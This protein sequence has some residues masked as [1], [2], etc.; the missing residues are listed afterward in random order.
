MIME[1]STPNAQLRV[2]IIGIAHESNTFLK[3]PT[4]L[5]DFQRGVFLR[6]EEIRAEYGAAHHEIAG[7]L[8]TLQA[9][10]IEAVPLFYAHATPGGAIAPGVADTLWNAAKEELEK[11][12]ELDGFLVAPHGA[13]V[14]VDH[15]DMD[16]WWLTELR[17]IVG[18]D[19]PIISTLDPHANVTEKMIAACDVSITYRRN[20]HLDQ[21]ARGL[22]AGALMVRTLHGEI[23]PT[24]AVSLP[25][26]AMNIERQ[27]TDGEPCLSLQNKVEEIRAR[28]KVLSASVILGFPYADVPE[29]GSGFIVAT[30]NDPALAAQYAQEL[31]D[32]LWQH[33][34]DF[35]G[36]MISIDEALE[37]AAHSPKP[38]CLL[39]MGDNVGGGSPADGTLLLHALQARGGLTGFGTLFDPE[40]VRQAQTVQ[41]GERIHL[42]MGGK[43]DPL[44]GA[45][46]EAEVT[47]RSFHEG[48][49]RETEARHGG[50]TNLNMGQAAV[51]D[52]D[53]GLTIMLT[54]RRHG[55][56]S[57]QQLISCDVDPLAYDVLIAKGVH[58]PVAA[59]APVCPT[60]I[61]VNTP[62]ITTADMDQLEY[63][64]RRKPLFPF[65][66]TA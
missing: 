52:T 26:F 66:E 42:S 55:S 13:A 20:P 15:G 35:R 39:D 28:P 37:Q 51:V 45:P 24:Q 16:G 61:R 5:E 29:M 63:Q 62:G 2:G 59:Y 23:K 22:E 1:P 7:F 43:T 47:V 58:A 31:T 38:V 56:S 64:N 17:N 65:E 27:F 49:Y 8:E 3:K 33:K 46:F 44:H 53:S 57:L 9:A 14:D 18:P 50:R 32:Y 60:L 4:T 48:K 10:G 21:K 12:G 30:D 36:V 54:S 34:E 41:P 6:G 25:P 19:I 40:A 11:A